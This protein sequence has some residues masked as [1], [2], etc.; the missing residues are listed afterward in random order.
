MQTFSKG[1]FFSRHRGWYRD[2]SSKM[3]MVRGCRATPALVCG[4]MAISSE[5]GGSVMIAVAESFEAMLYPVNTSAV[6]KSVRA[7]DYQ[8]SSMG[9]FTL[10]PQAIFV[11]YGIQ[12]RAKG[13]ILL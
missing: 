9:L 4:S 8:C 3:G 13:H 6:G 7:L 5:T 10:F 12:S 2:T 1:L 11:G